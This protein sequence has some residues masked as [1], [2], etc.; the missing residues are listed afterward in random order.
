MTCAVRFEGVSVYY[1][2][3]P[4]IREISLAIP[5]KQIFGVIGPAAS[6]K[7]TLLKC[8]NRTLE[9]TAGARLDGKVAVAGATYPGSATCTS[10]AAGWAWSFRCRWACR[11]RF[12]RTSPTPPAGPAFTPAASSTP[13]SSSASARRC[14]GT[15]CATGSTCWGRGFPAGSSSG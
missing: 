3:R 7:T 9:L 12:T 8:I 2:A 14:S 13:W 5:E 10:S 4:A 6:G 1:G 15:K 11:C